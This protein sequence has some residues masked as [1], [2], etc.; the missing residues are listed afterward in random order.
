MKVP[1]LKR[2]GRLEKHLQMMIL[3]LI[4]VNESLVGLNLGLKIIL[5]KM[6]RLNL[7]LKVIGVENVMLLIHTKMMPLI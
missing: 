4:Q 3:L 7:E 1:M 6:I 2:K 5:Q